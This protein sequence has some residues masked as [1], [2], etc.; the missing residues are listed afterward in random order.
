METTTL[1]HLPEQC[2]SKMRVAIQHTLLLRTEDFLV[3]NSKN[4][5]RFDGC[6]LKR[7][8]AD[9]MKLFNKVQMAVYTESTYVAGRLA[10]NCIH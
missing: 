8:Y 9:F 2:L 4:W 1:I 3:I 5:F 6:V 7:I 10:V